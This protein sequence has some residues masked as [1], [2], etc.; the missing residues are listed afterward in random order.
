MKTR[1]PTS[2]IRV[3]RWVGFICYYESM[4][5]CDVEQPMSVGV[6]ALHQPFM[7]KTLYFSNNANGFH[8]L[9]E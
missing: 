2:D 6:K 7:K 3:R 8:H 4:Q 9:L 5:A 1:W